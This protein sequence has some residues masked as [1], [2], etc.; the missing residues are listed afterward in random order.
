MAKSMTIWF[1]VIKGGSGTDIYTKR[2]SAALKKRGIK[3]KTTWFSSLYQ[4]APILLKS[5]KQLPETTIIHANSGNAFAFK[6][7]D[8][9]LVVTEHHCVFDPQYRPYKNFMQDMFHQSLIR[10]Y[11]KASFYE[12]AAITAVS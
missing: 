1:P 6:R 9:P 11:E 2:L 10:S 4:I 12:A 8:I 3:T 5:A 7:K